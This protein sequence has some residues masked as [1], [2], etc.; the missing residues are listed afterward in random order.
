MDLTPPAIRDFSLSLTYFDIDYRG[1]I[2]PPHPDPDL[3][4]TREA[5]LASLITQ[6]T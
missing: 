1:K 6:P 4:L 2:Q 3:F 5:R